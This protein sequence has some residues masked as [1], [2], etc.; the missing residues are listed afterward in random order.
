MRDED[1]SHIKRIFLR[2]YP[3]WGYISSSGEFGGGILKIEKKAIDDHLYSS[4]FA[5][6][7]TVLLFNMFRSQ[8]PQPFI[9]TRTYGQV[10]T[11]SQECIFDLPAPKKDISD[12]YYSNGP[13]PSYYRIKDDVT[14]KR[15]FADAFTQVGFDKV[16]LRDLK[17]ECMER[18]KLVTQ[19]FEAF[20]QG[21][22][23]GSAPNGFHL[24]KR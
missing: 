22:F 1:I 20:G 9:L 23:G 6:V 4:E 5:K 15:K 11:A 8:K 19:L 24:S 12:V 2:T 18:K 16:E 7:L 21:V 14:G 3:M 17:K 13:K 10:Y